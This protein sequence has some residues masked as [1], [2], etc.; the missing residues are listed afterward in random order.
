MLGWRSPSGKPTG[1]RVLGKF[2]A[3]A[4]CRPRGETIQP[5]IRSNPLIS[6][7]LPGFTATFGRRIS[8]LRKGLESPVP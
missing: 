5:P 8:T 2:R 6:K 7:G 4:D 1:L 3:S